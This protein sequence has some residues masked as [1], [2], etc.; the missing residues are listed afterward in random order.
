MN[1]LVAGVLLGAVYEVG[2][3][4]AYCQQQSDGGLVCDY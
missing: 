3:V 4:D 2:L 1:V